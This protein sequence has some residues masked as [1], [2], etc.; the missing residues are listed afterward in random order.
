M[1]IF[2]IL[3]SVGRYTSTVSWSILWI[4]SPLKFPKSAPFPKTPSV[5]KLKIIDRNS[6]KKYGKY[7]VYFVFSYFPIFL[8]QCWM[9]FWNLV[10]N[11]AQ[12]LVP[13]ARLPDNESNRK[14]LIG[15][16]WAA[17][18]NWI[19]VN[20]QPTHVPSSSSRLWWQLQGVL[21]SIDITQ[22][23]LLGDSI[24][25]FQVFDRISTFTRDT[26]HEALK[27]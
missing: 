27:W 4:Q 14:K 12:F 19:D 23:S 21:S 3:N 9:K 6:G 20:C 1:L 2:I 17:I 7:S 15:R 18:E 8:L 22:H 5:T 26:L 11:F 25:T 13:R 16:L 10:Q 24:R